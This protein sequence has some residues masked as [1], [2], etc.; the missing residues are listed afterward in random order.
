[1]QRSVILYDIVIIQLK[2]LK[3]RTNYDYNVGQIRAILELPNL[4]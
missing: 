2:G 4:L 3:A 1:M